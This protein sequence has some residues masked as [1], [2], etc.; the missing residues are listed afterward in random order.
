MVIGTQPQL[1]AT[2]ILLPRAAIGLIERPRLLDMVVQ[3]QAKQLT[4]IKAGAGFGKTSLAVG[5][6]ER[7]QQSGNLVAW[8]ALDTEDNEPTRFLFYVSHALRHACSSLGEEAIDLILEASLNLPRTIVSMLINDLTN[9]DD[10]VFLFLDDYYWLTHPEIQAVILFLLRRAPSNLHLVFITRSEPSVSLARLRAQNQLL[11]VDASALRFDLDETRQFL[12]QENIRRIEASDVRILHA[13]TEGWPA[14]LRIIALTFSQ[15]A[16]EFGQFVLRLSGAGRPIGTYLDEMLD[17]LPSE[18]VQFMVRTAILDRFS[19]SLC[20]AVTGQNSSGG[21]L[22]SIESRQLLL[23]PL[24]QE[25]QWYRYHPLL[26]EYLRQRLEA[27]SGDKIPELQRRASRWFAAN[28]MWADAVQYAIWAGDTDQAANW[29]ENCAMALVKRGDMLTLLSWQR[30]LPADLMRRQI[31]VR[32]AIAWGLALAMRFEEALK[33]AAEIEQ[34]IGSADGAAAEALTC[35]CQTIRSVAVALQ[36]DSHNALL[37]AEAC[38]KHDPADPWTANVASNV[39]RFGYWRGGDLKSF[40]ATPWIP[41]TADE[42]KWNV[43]AS[44][45]RLCLQGLVEV[46]QLRVDVADRHYLEAMRLAEQHVGASSV[47]AALPASLIAI[48][49]YEQGRLEEA[50]SLIIDRLPIINAAGMLECAA[51]AY[52]TL[53]RIAACRMN[54]QRVFA[55]LGQAE[56]IGHTRKWGRL[57]AMAQFW[58]LQLYLAEGRASE[59]RACLDGLERLAEAYPAPLTCAWST[60]HFITAFG[61]ARLA[62]V[63]NRLQDSIG[64]LRAL[65]HDAE[66]TN[67]HY[68]ALMIAIQLSTVLLTANKPA[69]ASKTFCDALKT[70]ASAGIYQMI[71][72]GGPQI[73]RLLAMFQENAQRTGHYRELLP[74][75]D[76]LVARW[77]ERYEPKLTAIARPAI[78]EVLSARERNIIELISRGQSNKEIARGLGIAPETVKSHVKHIFVKLDV[79]KRTRAVVRAQSLG[80]VSTQ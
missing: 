7:L 68:L 28:E 11:E 6:A 61:R 32:L 29:I 65:Q 25:R 27:Q 24:D 78:A 17:G 19:A 45:Y 31:K 47:A 79:D 67:R 43:F 4:I 73:G 30:L 20:Q 54:M 15:S 71:L 22:E 50:E 5:W 76:D 51:C 69:E 8:L 26:A 12:E 3:V 60:I 14:I 63:D 21:V 55:L 37:L 41:Y 35:E 53:V 18:I 33:L 59:A 75:A 70:T 77:R 57:I 58:R 9:I 36:D 13:K 80:I 62:S 2:K 56:N 72:D 40:Y 38:L 52:F 64:I 16:E 66:M 74:Y 23:T 49:S 44:V 10:E 34:D 48:R 39:A 42:D 46:E 1:L